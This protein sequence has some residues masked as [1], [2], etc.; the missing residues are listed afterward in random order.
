MRR[1]RHMNII[2][3][4][5]DLP[6]TEKEKCSSSANA[7]KAIVYY[8]LKR[9]EREK[10]FETN[11]SSPVAASSCFDADRKGEKKRN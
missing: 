9:K 5:A 8:C 10:E 1:D 6:A 7:P 4:A 2:K 3:T 11:L